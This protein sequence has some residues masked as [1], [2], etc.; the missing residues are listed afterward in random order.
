MLSASCELRFKRA[1]R[2]MTSR[3]CIAHHYTNTVL[4]HFPLCSIGMTTYKTTICHSQWSA[5]RATNIHF[6]F[7]AELQWWLRSNCA[8]KLFII[9]HL[10]AS[11]RPYIQIWIEKNYLL[12]FC[13]LLRIQLLFSVLNG[14]AKNWNAKNIHAEFLATT[15]WN[16]IR[17]QLGLNWN[18]WRK[19]NGKPSGN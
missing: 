15:T 12:P 2:S 17:K 1:M 14:H 10:S 6:E 18:F 19:K 5:M 11:I 13:V 4:I 16:E 8:N 3:E 7:T 9:A